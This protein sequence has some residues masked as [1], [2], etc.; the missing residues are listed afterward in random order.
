MRKYPGSAGTCVQNESRCFFCKN[1]KRSLTRARVTYHR[2]VENTKEYEHPRLAV[3]HVQSSPDPRDDDQCP[4]QQHQLHFCKE[5]EEK[6][7]NAS[8]LK[9][10]LQAAQPV[11]L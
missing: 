7:S 2:D 3:D 11:F 4:E 8:E 1:E 9:Q 6:E 5:K 10:Q